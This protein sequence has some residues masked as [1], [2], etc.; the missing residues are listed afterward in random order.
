LTLLQTFVTLA[1][2]D[3]YGKGSLVLGCSLRKHKTTRQLVVLITPQ[4][5]QTVRT[6]L[7]RIFD[8]VLLVDVLKSQD[9][10]KLILKKTPELSLML[11]KL[12]C[13]DLTRYSK[14]VFMDADTMALM[15]IDELFEWEEL[16]AVADD[17]CSDCF[18]TGV[19]VFKPSTDTHKALL[20]FA[21]EKGSFDNGNQGLLNSFFS[22]WAKVDISKHL[23]FTYNLNCNSVHFSTLKPQAAA[24]KVIHFL[25]KTKP[26]NYSYDPNTKLVKDHDLSVT[27]PEYVY[28]WWDN[29]TSSVLPMLTEHGVEEAT[30]STKEEKITEALT[31]LS[32]IPPTVTASSEER[33]QRW[34]QG[35]VDFMGAD[36]F[37]NI[38]KKLDAYLN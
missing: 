24:A 13:W 22:N 20:K 32:I 30:S 14:C 2:N 10:S 11:A 36:S 31:R 12:Y 26:W 3:L 28:M 19:F 1:A 9:S 38:Q 16:S 37:Q 23:P 6:V 5:S 33:R 18:N 17:I 21:M 34:E 35:Q 29:F 27:H 8:E 4:V 7:G 15:N 25:G